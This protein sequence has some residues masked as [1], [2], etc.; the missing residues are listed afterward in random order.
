MVMIIVSFI[1]YRMVWHHFLSCTGSCSISTSRRVSSRRNIAESPQWPSK[2]LKTVNC[3]PRPS[4]RKAIDK[5]LTRLRAKMTSW[6]VTA[7]NSRTESVFRNRLGVLR[8]ESQNAGNT[9]SSSLH[10][11]RTYG[12]RVVSTDKMV[13]KPAESETGQGLKGRDSRPKRDLSRLGEFHRRQDR[14]YA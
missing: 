7:D 13:S 10:A 12:N 4:E 5:G 11:P 9:Y 2:L 14:T 8:L 6:T 1:S 3:K